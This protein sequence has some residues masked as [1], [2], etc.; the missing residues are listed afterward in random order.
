LSYDHDRDRDHDHD[1]DRD[2]DHDP[3]PDRDRDRDVLHLVDLVQPEL[4][5]AAFTFGR[6]EFLR[7][8]PRQ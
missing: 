7:F 3:N 2:H 1:P 5:I 6:L 8:P 4:R